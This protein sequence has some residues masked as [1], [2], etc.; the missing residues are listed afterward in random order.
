M[1]GRVS[2]YDTAGELRTE[3]SSGPERQPEAVRYR[4]IAARTG[5]GSVAVFPAP[6]QYF[7]PRDFTTNMSYIWHSSWKGQ[8][9]L[10]IRQL[11]DDATAYYPW[12]N[13]PP[14]TEQHMSMFLLLDRGDPPAALTG[15]LRYTH[16]DRF[17][18][19]DGYIRFAPHRHYAYKHP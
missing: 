12:S 2:Y 8:V 7:F 10:G 17:P 1:E 3:L 9:A 4:T 11:P 13:A 16:A 18:A 14:G 6:H 5:T 19:L 15:V